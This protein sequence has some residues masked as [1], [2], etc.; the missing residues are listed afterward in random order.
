MYSNY[1]S[2]MC[3]PLFS[4]KGVATHTT[5]TKNLFMLPKRESTNDNV[6]GESRRVIGVIVYVGKGKKVSA[7]KPWH[8]NP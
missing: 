1:N 4:F 5:E 7:G 2:L 8:I 3:L 6:D